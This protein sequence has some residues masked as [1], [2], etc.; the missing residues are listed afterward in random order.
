MT[1]AT[2][3]ELDYFNFKI[4]LWQLPSKLFCVL[5]WYIVETIFQL[6]GSFAKYFRH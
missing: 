5:Y 2:T 3:F 1:F 6:Y 4:K